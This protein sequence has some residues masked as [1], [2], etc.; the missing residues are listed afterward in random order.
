MQQ[1]FSKKIKKISLSFNK[2]PTSA[3]LACFSQIA[4]WHR[5]FSRTLNHLVNYVLL[6]VVFRQCVFGRLQTNFPARD[7]TV[8]L[9]CSFREAASAGHDIFQ[10]IFK[11]ISDHQN[12]TVQI[13]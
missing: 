3:V 12:N 9:T 6:F 1:F 8:T 2:S 5:P 4:Y 13:N 10:S 7:N 11:E